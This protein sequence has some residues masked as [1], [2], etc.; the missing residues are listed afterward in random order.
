MT[1]KSYHEFVAL[2]NKELVPAFGCTEPIAIAYVAAKA[3]EVLKKIPERMIVSCSGNIVKNVKGVIVPATG[4]LKGIE[5]A[6][7]IGAVGGDASQEL[8]V[9]GHVS[10][11][12]RE[13]TAALLEQGICEARLLKTDE[14]LHIVVEAICRE[15]RVTVELKQ[16]HTNIVR[17]EKNGEILFAKTEE[18]K[19]EEEQENPDFLNFSSIY[20]FAGQV[21]MEDVRQVLERQVSYNMKIAE[22]GLTHEYGASVGSMLLET[23]GKNDIKAIA[24]AL[25]AAGSDAR[26]G[27]CE[28]PVIINSGSGNQGMTV[29]L[30]VIAYAGELKASKEQLYRALCVSNLTA[31]YQKSGIG[32][33]S[34]YCGAVSAAAGAGAGIAYLM[35]GSKEEISEVVSNTLA[36]VA[37]II[38]DGAKASCAA[39]IASSVEAAILAVNLTFKGKSFHAGEGI[40]KDDPNTTVD[41][42]ATIAREGMSKTDEVV[43][44]VMVGR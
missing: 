35:G 24:R 25:P 3:R 26:M 7:V 27:G 18:K 29:S 12:D 17:I 21:R 23:Y 14:K 34:A 44:D 15:D 28:L 16:S 32:R 41:G 31:I 6:A 10:D 4:G 42:I 38:C 43:L 9:L 22:Y 36:N 13:K 20:E 19:E 5:A 11:A 8:E 2:L 33:L 37:G 1:E 30:P 40:V 39:K